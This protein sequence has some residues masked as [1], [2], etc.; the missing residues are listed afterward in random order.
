M[1]QNGESGGS[2]SSRKTSS[3]AKAM[4]PSRRPLQQRLLVD[5]RAAP[6]VDE[7]RPRFERGELGCSQEV[8][9]LRGERR[10]D[11]Q[12]VGF[13]QHPVQLL[14]AI[15]PVDAQRSR[16]RRIAVSSHGDDTHAERARDAGDLPADATRSDD[17]HRPPGEL[18]A[19]EAMPLVRPLFVLEPA[20]LLRVV[21]QRGKHELGEWLGV[22]TTGGGDDKVG[23]LQAEPLHQR[24]DARRRRL[25]PTH[26]RREL[27]ERASLV[28]R[29]IEQ[30]LRLGQ[31]AVP[32]PLL[33]GVAPPGGI[34]MVRDV[35]RRGHQIGTKDD[36]DLI[37]E[38]AGDAFDILGFER[39]CQ[40]H[41]DAI[42]APVARHSRSIRQRVQRASQHLGPR[43]RVVCRGELVRTVT[44]AS[45]GADED[46]GNLRDLG[47]LHGVVHRA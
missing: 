45:P 18:D 42:A 46:H 22:D 32:F 9:C 37:R 8:F 12:A 15:E 38:R 10:A 30:D 19:G 27:Q 33:L 25:H 5:D 11:D 14:A 47:E 2:G 13:S 40:H 26:L 28:L 1:S 23:I 17:G 3:A 35:A 36:V 4:R 44:D 34:A 31:E 41:H 29:E 20:D 6:D 24:T 16:P 7:D 39:R 21:E 43:G